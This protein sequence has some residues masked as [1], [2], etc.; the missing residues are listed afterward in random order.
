MGRY[1]RNMKKQQPRKDR[2]KK[3]GAKIVT[4]DFS[5]PEK[6]IEEPMGEPGT[7]NVQSSETNSFHTIEEPILKDTTQNPDLL[8]IKKEIMPTEKPKPGTLGAEEAKDMK[9]A[10]IAAA[11]IAGIVILLM[12]FNVFNT[13]LWDYQH[14]AGGF[15][16][17]IGFICLLVSGS[18]GFL[19]KKLFPLAN[20]KI[21]A[22]LFFIP[23]VLGICWGS[24][25][26]FDLHG[27]EPGA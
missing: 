20:A 4:S 23:L 8:I 1:K 24:G 5:P 19:Y 15:D 12:Y 16:R 13:Y 21:F 17:V 9:T 2:E 22:L 25:F 14:R 6:V 10:A 3:K 26:N 7:L 18:S 11:V 27:I